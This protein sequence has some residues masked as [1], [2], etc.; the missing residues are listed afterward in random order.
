MGTSSSPVAGG[1]TAGSGTYPGGTSVTVTALAN[2]GYA[3][4][5]WTE[6]GSVVGVAA[7]NSFPASENCTLV[8]NFVQTWSIETR[9]LPAG[10][11][12][13]RGDG[14]FTNG[15]SV[16]VTASANPG[17]SFLNWTEGGAV[18]S[19]QASFSFTANTEGVQAPP[20]AQDASD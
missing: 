6:A 20:I 18:V 14:T 3:F 2:P 11:G 5:N 4:V 15:T 12:L 16:T 9:A 17:Y 10:S 19:T 13:T 1:T 8:A 7:S